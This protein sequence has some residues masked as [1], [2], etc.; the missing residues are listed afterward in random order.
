V[1]TKLFA[2][3]YGK[4]DGKE[5]NPAAKNEIYAAWNPA[6]SRSVE[7][8]N[9][10]ETWEGNSP[11]CSGFYPGENRYKDPARPQVNF[12]IMMEDRAATE[13]REKTPKAGNTPGCAGCR[14]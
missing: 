5:W 9:P 12:A 10:Y 13:E 14:T 2:L 3:D 8:F 1:S 4:Y 7:N 6:A 11:D